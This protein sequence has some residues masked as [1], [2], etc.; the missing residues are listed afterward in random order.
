MLL[1]F[2]VV[3]LRQVM[4]LAE[5]RVYLSKSW[6]LKHLVYGE[7]FPDENFKLKHTRPGLLSMVTES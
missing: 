7:R 2:Q 3:I 1:I 4:G 5:N 6:E